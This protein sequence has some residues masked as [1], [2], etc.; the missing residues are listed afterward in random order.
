MFLGMNQKVVK[1]I[2][3]KPPLE[4]KFPIFSRKKRK[5]TSSYKV[6]CEYEEVKELEKYHWWESKEERSFSSSYCIESLFHRISKK[7]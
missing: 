3:N 5:K 2:S 4:K 7:F 1:K 6:N